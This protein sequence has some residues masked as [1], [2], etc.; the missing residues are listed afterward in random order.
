M[1]TPTMLYRPGDELKLAHGSFDT[2]IVDADDV[3]E[4]IAEGWR[5]APVIDTPIDD[6]APA[7]RDEMETR[8][9]DLGIRGIHLM[10]DATLAARIAEFD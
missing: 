6:N 4:M 3:P 9:K 10:K 2:I 8:A 5:D 7:T 1:K